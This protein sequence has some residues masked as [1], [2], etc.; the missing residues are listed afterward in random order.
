MRPRYL[1]LIA[2]AIVLGDQWTK[3]LVKTQMQL[4][5]TIP[6]LGK[7]LGLTYIHNMGGAFGVFQGKQ[8]LFLIT[9]WGVTAALI[10]YLPKIAKMHWVSAV[11]YALILG[12]AIGNLLDRS[13]YSYVVDFVEVGLPGPW[14]HNFTW[15]NTFPCF[16]VAD[17]GITV[18]ITVLLIASILIPEKKEEPPLPEPAEAASE[19]AEPVALPQTT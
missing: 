7:Y 6:L 2:L 8:W 18:G 9:G 3:Y 1:L 4:G 10:V 13:R 5:Q 14:G 17:S 19:S 15:V 16:N 11:S 12:G